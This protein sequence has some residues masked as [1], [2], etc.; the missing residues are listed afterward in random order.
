[1]KNGRHG[2]EIKYRYKIIYIYILILFFY[3]LFFWVY[4]DF[5]LM[6]SYIITVVDSKFIYI[7]M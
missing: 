1:M 4:T 7:I 6:H 3:T 2:G 5:Y